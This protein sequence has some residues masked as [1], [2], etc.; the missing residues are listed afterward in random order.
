MIF[1]S[2]QGQNSDICNSCIHHANYYHK[3]KKMK[4]YYLV[5]LL[6]FPVIATAQSSGSLDQNNLSQTLGIASEQALS[7]YRDVQPLKGRL[8]RTIDEKGKLVSSNDKWW[9]SGFFPGTLWYLYEFSGKEEL[10]K[11]ALEMTERVRNQQYTTDNHDVGFMI[12]CSFGNAYRLT[13]DTH[14][15]KVIVNAAK[16]LSTRFNPITGTLKSWDNRRWQY[17]VIIDNMMNLELLTQATNISGD[18]SFYKIAV[19]HADTTMKYHFRPDGSSYHV[20]NYDTIHGG[21]IERVTFQGYADESSWARG[22]AWGLYGYVM[23]YRETRKQEYLHHAIKIADFLVNHPNLPKDGIPYWDFNAP[24][25]PDA[26]RDASAGAV[27]AS[28]LIELSTFTGDKHTTDYLAAAEKMLRTLSSS[29]YLASNG[30][31]GHFILKHSVGFMAK[32]S[33]VDVPLT[34]ADYYFVEALLRYKK[35]VHEKNNQ[36]VDRRIW[37]ESM[38]KIADPV[39]TNLSQHTLKAQM[40]VETTPEGSTRGREKV[41]HLEAL[42]RTVCGIAPWLEL[43]ADTSDEGKLREKY[44]QITLK[45]LKN[46][47]D[48]T[49]PDFIGFTIDRQNLVDAAFLAEGFLRAPG[50]LWGGLDKK[51]QELMIQSMLATRMFKP[52]ESNW[53]LF[54]ATIEAFLYRFTG[55]CNFATIDYALKRFDEWYKGDSWYGDGTAFHFDY[56]NS[57]VIHPMLY[58]VLNVVK[59]VSPEYQKWFDVQ[60][61]RLT[62]H[63]DQLERLI[64]P[65]GTYPAIGRSLVYRFGSFHALS[66]AALLKMLPEHLSPAQTRSALTAVIQKQLAQNGTFDKNGWLTLGFAGHQPNLAES[67]ISTGSL[68][69]CSAVFLPLGLPA[70]DAFWTTQPEDWTNK[71]AWKGEYIKIDKAIKK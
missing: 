64:S 65:E 33:E 69:L 13:G 1:V 43:D 63:A 51:T 7:L 12:Y 52:V 25:I 47:V 26:L 42:G 28:A 60:S 58:D 67:Y 2:L 30:E 39:L 32:N 5:L 23:M 66:Q 17:P 62:R 22:Q 49:S 37:I 70:T 46:A 71:K 19:S 8:P 44:L 9:T 54:S 27:I 40:P 31:N 15:K 14:L 11:A 18:S 36:Q 50:K 48:S 24:N 41:T 34:Y 4:F 35:L 68:Y 53:L 16:S 29:S 3:N 10:Q 55:N 61:V 45:A 21:F 38:L 56:Y 57:L 20:V 6:F 59:T